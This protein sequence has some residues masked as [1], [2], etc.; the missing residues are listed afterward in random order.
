MAGAERWVRSLR[1]LLIPVVVAAALWAAVPSGHFQYAR[2]LF[3]PASSCASCHNGLVTDAGEDVSIEKAWRSS[4]MAHSARDPYWQASVRREVMDHP[5]EAREIENECA[6]CHMPMAAAQV[7]S[8]GRLLSV[9]G[10]LPPATAPPA[11][12]TLAVDGVSC[13]VCHQ[14]APAGLGTAA[15]FNGRFVV[16]TLAAPGKRP[17]Y[18]P[19]DID[20]G[21]AAVMHSASAFLPARGD[22]IRSSELCATCHTLHT[23]AR[24]ATG[25]VVGRLPE[26]VPF[27]EWKHSSYASRRS[28]RSCHMP[29]A[30]S[31]FISGVLGQ[32]RELLARHD[33]RG[34][35]FFMLSMLERYRAETGVTTPPGEL[36]AAAAATRRSLETDAATV[37]ITRYELQSDTLALSVTVTNLTG[38]KLPTAYPSRRVWLELT[39]REA[40]AGEE[41]V[42]FRSGALRPDGSIAGA[43][44]DEA[45]GETGVEQHYTVIR[46][47]GEVQIY[48]SVMLDAGGAVTTG[49]LSAVRYIK[50]NR[51]L[52]DG[53]DKATAP[54]DAAVR[55]SASSDADF[56]G[57]SDQL[58]YRVGVA[59]RGTRFI[60]EATLW[61][62]PVAF[63]WAHNLARY[64]ATETRRFVSWYRE[65]APE[66]ATPLARTSTTVER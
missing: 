62:Q 21:R 26:Q 54:D 65:M 38:H 49:L 64:D 3:E 44:S 11:S 16:D 4:M 1:A 22:H 12:V 25:R 29:P 32:K 13:T 28:C 18:G 47:E 48:E 42:V 37:T 43:D 41:R 19:Y 8:G 66:S 50:D 61:Y 53:F 14:I 17:V 2:Q 23:E 34:G 57:G 59:G 9:F 31:T 51:I 10:H 52:P 20:S 63:R 46:N 36:S 39:V 6:T 33:F 56:S 27:I 7:R 5:R 58:Q 35:N 24:D 30:E 45:G 55:G 15:T 60:V 40:G